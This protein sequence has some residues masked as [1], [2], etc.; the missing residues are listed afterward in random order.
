MCNWTWIGYEKDSCTESK[1]DKT[2]LEKFGCTTPFGPNKDKIC[3]DQENGS[4]VMEL[5]TKTMEQNFDNCNNPCLF[6]STKATKTSEVDGYGK[7]MITLKENIQVI[8]AYYL[9]S[10]L[11]LIA[12]VGGYVG[13][14]LG[15]SVNQVSTLVNAALDKLDWINK[16]FFWITYDYIVFQGLYRGGLVHEKRHMLC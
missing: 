13:L 12:E 15:V 10:G 8:E 1:L 3:K 14:F 6:V 7:V 2:S 4:K 11:S 5:Y 9:Y 16:R